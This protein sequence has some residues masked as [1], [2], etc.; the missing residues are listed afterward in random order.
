MRSLAAL[1]ILVSSLLAG[2]TSAEAFYYC[3]EPT[4]PSCTSRFGSFDDEWEFDRCKRE[5]KNYQSD[6]ETFIACNNSANEQAVSDYSDAVKKFNR[7]AGN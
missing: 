3:T 2:S 7:R 6:V 4:A 5:M 1:G